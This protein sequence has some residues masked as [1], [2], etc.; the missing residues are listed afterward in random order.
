MKTLS[1]LACLTFITAPF[2]TYAEPASQEFS[3]ASKHS[4]LAASHGINGSAQVASGVIAVP[5]VVTAG[6]AIGASVASAAIEGSVS[7]LADASA[8]KVVHSHD[9]E[10]EITEITITVDQAPKDAMKSQ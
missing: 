4:A 6:V 9:V 10:L 5:I 1:Y 3:H 8:R 2:F 7:E